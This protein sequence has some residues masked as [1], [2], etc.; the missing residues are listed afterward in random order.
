MRLPFAPL[1]IANARFP[2]NPC[3]FCC[4]PRERRAEI[5][6]KD[7]EEEELYNRLSREASAA[8]A[9]EAKEAP[10]QKKATTRKGPEL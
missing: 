8:S 4:P 5:R 7:V 10:A 9:S 2:F 1:D 3:P 6:K